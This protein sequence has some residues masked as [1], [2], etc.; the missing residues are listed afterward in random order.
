MRYL[1]LIL[2]FY[3]CTL[4]LSQEPCKKLTRKGVGATGNLCCIDEASESDKDLIYAQAYL[5]DS[6]NQVHAPFGLPKSKNKHIIILYSKGYI[7]GY[8]TVYHV[9]IWVQYKMW[10]NKEWNENLTREDCFRPDPRLPAHLQIS[11]AHYTHSGFDRGHIKPAN[12]AKLNETEHFNS[13]VMSNMAPQYPS[14]NRQEW[15]TIEAY[16]NGHSRLDSVKQAYMVTGSIVDENP[17]LVSDK[18]A[19]PSWFYKIYFFQ[20]Q[21][22]NW[23][24][25]VFYVKNDDIKV[26]IRDFEQELIANTVSIDEIESLTK[27]NFNVCKKAIR[28]TEKKTNTSHLNVG[29]FYMGYSAKYSEN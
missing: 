27:T 4:A 13:F 12:D 11:H 9:P 24:Q 21:S 5:R 3:V 17:E 19:V 2:S 29:M 22:S 20:G 10:S 6:L 23:H 25:W 18:I 1:S 28:A 14:M 7:C 16:L 8:D 26:D 15:M